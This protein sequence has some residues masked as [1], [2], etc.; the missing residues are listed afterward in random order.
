MTWRIELTRTAEMQI[1]KLDRTSQARI[2]SYLRQRILSAANPRQFGKALQ[3][4]KQGLWRCRVGDFRI[5][6]EIQDV[7][8]CLL[9]LAV[10]HRREVYR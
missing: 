9:V 10:A 2:V 7:N 5:I 3:G 4:D 8:S 1:V 6:C